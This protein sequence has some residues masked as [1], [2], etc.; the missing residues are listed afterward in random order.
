MAVRPTRRSRNSSGLKPAA[1]VIRRSSNRNRRAPIPSPSIRLASTR[2]RTS[3]APD[4][5]FIRRPNF[6]FQLGANRAAIRVRASDNKDV[7]D[8]PVEWAFGAGKQA[9]TFVT[10]VNQDWYIEHY[11]SYYSALGSFAP[12]PGQGAVVAH[13]LSEAMGILYKIDDSQ[14]GIL[15]C[16]ECHST[17]PVSYGSEREL[18]PMELGVRCEACHGAG[19]LHRAA[20]LSGNLKK[21]RQFIQN[22]KRMSAPDLIRFCGNCHREPSPNGASTDWNFPWNV[23]HQPVYLSQSACFRKSGALSCLTCH[24]PHQKL[25][26]DDAAYNAQCRACHTPESYTPK[27]V[28]LAK[29]SAS[30]AGCHMPKVSPQSYLRFTNHWIGVYS[31][32]AKLK[33]VR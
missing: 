16:F 31:D 9:V 27:Q 24:D 12:T 7:M 4:K 6:Q 1:H 5:Q 8:I 29:P 32:N 10:R 15:K 28:C 30:C 2:S 33:P 21:A 20:V 22:P 11:L 18:Q 26:N 19:S 25:Q 3:F 14:A 17:G 23:R 13:T